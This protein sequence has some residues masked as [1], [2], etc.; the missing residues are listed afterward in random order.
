MLVRTY[1]R[2]GGASPLAGREDA[3][4]LAFAARCIHPHRCGR[5]AHHQ[6]CPGSVPK[7]PRPLRT[8]AAC[9][10]RPQ[11]Q[12]TGPL[13]PAAAMW[14]ASPGGGIR[15]RPCLPARRLPLRSL[16]R[17]RAARFVAGR[18]SSSRSRSATR[19]LSSRSSPR[20]KPPAGWPAAGSPTGSSRASRSRGCCASPPPPR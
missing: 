9:A 16:K 13:G 18:R 15:S 19:R 14:H 8:L 10:S 6:C 2:T 7:S 4:L 12:Q 5:D 11:E 1:V 3:R 17:L 20:A